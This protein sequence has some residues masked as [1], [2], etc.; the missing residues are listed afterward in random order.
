MIAAAVLTALSIGAWWLQRVA[1]SPSNDSNVAHSILGDEEI[2]GQIATIVAGADATIL[3]EGPAADVVELSDNFGAV[4]RHTSQSMQ[5][6]S[7]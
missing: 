4:V 7:T 6:E 3:I 1:F 2:R 5:L